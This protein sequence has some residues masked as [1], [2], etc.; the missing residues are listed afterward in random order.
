MKYTAKHEGQTIIESQ[1][2]KSLLLMLN[3]NHK[4]K[5]VSLYQGRIPM[6]DITIPKSNRVKLKVF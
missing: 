3:L 6:M 1:S 2:L 5:I 4:G